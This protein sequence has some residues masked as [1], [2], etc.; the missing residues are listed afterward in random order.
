MHLK[1]GW[2]RFGCTIEQLNLLVVSGRVG[3]GPNFST[4][5]GSGRVGHSAGG[6]GWIGSHKADPWTAVRGGGDNGKRRHSSSDV[7]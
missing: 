1:R 3:L 6:L 5:S 4:C 7:D 2:I